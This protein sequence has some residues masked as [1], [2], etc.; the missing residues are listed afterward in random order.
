MSASNDSFSAAGKWSLTFVPVLAAVLAGCQARPA[1]PAP[2]VAVVTYTVHASEGQGSTSYPAE[3]APRY[4]NPLA[5]RV[6]GKVIERHVRLG[7]RVTA[8]EVLARLDS[9]DQE[10][11][12]ASARAVLTAS[13]HRLKYAQQQLERDNTQ[14]AHQ[15]IA[16]NQLEQ[17]EDAHA[18]ALAAR[19][20]AADALRVAENTLRYHSLT[21][22]HDGFITSENV[23]TGQVVSAGQPVYQLAWSGDIDVVIDTAAAD[24]NRI[25]IGEPASVRLPSTR[26]Q[27]FEA[28][29]REIAP[30]ADPQSRTFR[31][32]LTL[33]NPAANVRLGTVGEATLL[34]PPERAQEHIPERAEAAPGQAYGSI[35][36]PAPARTL[37]GEID[38]PA[39]ALFHQ[40]ADPAVWVL[41]G[42]QAQLALRRVAVLRY[43]DRSVILSG[44]LKE[45]E[46][47]VAVGVHAVFAG[48][49]VAPSVSP[50]DEDGVRRP[51][52]AARIANA[53]PGREVR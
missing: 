19:D 12:V 37:A 6:G 15:L 33:R 27:P 52:F 8:G 40:G 30:S 17:S 49:R 50:F 10:R 46:R 47:I 53:Q 9:I 21:A 42:A 43:Q 45:G 34:P 41:Q 14:F 5:F 25:V 2:P 18:A 32:K 13:Q 3:V 28:Y 20:E 44:G 51:A 48:E 4:S 29:V 26:E 39:T 31:I 16:T 22:E 38:I 11:Q 1:T 36:Q 35:P 23:D 7:D 24:A